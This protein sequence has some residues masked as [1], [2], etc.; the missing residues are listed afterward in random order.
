MKTH[1]ASTE[2]EMSA[3][4][5]L[6]ALLGQ[7]SG[8]SLRE[9]KRESMGRNRSFEILAHVDV[10]GHSHTL[11][12]KVKALAT[13][14]Q[15]RTALRDLCAH[16]VCLSGDATPVLIAPTLSAEAQQLCKE[17]RAGFLDL[18][19]NARLILGD[20]FIGMR[21]L[22]CSSANRPPAPS[23]G[24]LTHI[25]DPDKLRRFPE[26]GAEIALIA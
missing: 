2:L 25:I 10:Y 4:E 11:A 12:C 22:P 23:P 3:V 6:T 21:S 1:I 13:P 15:L 8:I 5:A 16:A 24:A 7:I 26:R 9:V 18:E 14:G 19:G 17:A 20:F